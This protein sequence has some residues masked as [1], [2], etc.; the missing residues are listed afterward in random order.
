MIGEHETRNAVRGRDVGGF[1]GK[2]D[3]DGGRTP[4]DEG[5]EAAFADAEEGFVDLCRMSICI[6][7]LKYQTEIK[8]NP[9]IE[10]TLREMDESVIKTYIS[11]VSFSLDDVKNRNV[12][13]LLAGVC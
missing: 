12:T 10:M 7:N 9:Y 5:G 2:G 1:T 6:K 4:R 13:A 3:L 8:R 11:R